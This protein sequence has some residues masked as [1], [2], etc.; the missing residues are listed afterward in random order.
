MRKTS[1]ILGKHLIGG[2]DKILFATPSEKIPARENGLPYALQ[3]QV[4]VR[5][6]FLV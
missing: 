1:Y 2:S 5:V 4:L 6:V 3:V